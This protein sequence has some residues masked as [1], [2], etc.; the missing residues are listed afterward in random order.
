MKPTMLVS[1]QMA[2]GTR[3]FVNDATAEKRL[4]GQKLS[5]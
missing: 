1:V 4:S 5:G 2:D 3:I